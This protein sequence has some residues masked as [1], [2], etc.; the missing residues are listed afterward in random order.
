MADTDSRFPLIEIDDVPAAD[1]GIAS[2]TAPPPP[3]APVAEIPPVQDPIDAFRD[4]MR[5]QRAE[6]HADAREAARRA[7]QYENA[8]ALPRR[9]ITEDLVAV[10]TPDESTGAVVYWTLSGAIDLAAITAAWGSLPGEWMPRKPSEATALS[11][12]AAEQRGR[13][14]LVR[15]DPKG[16]WAIITER[17]LDQRLDF[18]QAARVFLDQEGKLSVLDGEEQPLTG[19]LADHIRAS[20]AATLETVGSDDASEWLTNTMARLNAVA[21]RQTGGIYFVPRG[22]VERFRALK[23]AVQGASRHRIFEIAAMK[24]SEAVT[25]VLDA[26]QR[27]VDALAEQVRGELVEGFGARA[28]STR[29]GQIQA[30]SSKVLSYERLLGTPLAGARTALH[31]LSEEVSASTSRASMLEVR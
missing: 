6:E 31:K 1:R 24:S 10:S 11:R 5:E 19:Q 8:H 15:R 17:A 28:A 30:L 14:C 29:V 3:P 2:V 4:R 12:A 27:E 16:G 22:S 20:F 13:S 21:L 18:N 7:D 25:S 26:L 23:A 9:A